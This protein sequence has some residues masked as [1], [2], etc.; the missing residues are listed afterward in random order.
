MPS[1]DR[2]HLQ[3]VTA[4]GWLVAQERSY[5]WGDD[6]LFTRLDDLST[7]ADDWIDLD[8]VHRVNL[9]GVTRV[10]ISFGTYAA[11]NYQAFLNDDAGHTVRISGPLVLRLQDELLR[12]T[13]EH[14]LLDRALL[15]ADAAPQMNSRR[16]S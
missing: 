6:D 13:R 15:Q 2:S 14:S 10:H 7:A 12:R 11:P 3:P 8:P 16:V 9:A 5:E 1:G 4:T